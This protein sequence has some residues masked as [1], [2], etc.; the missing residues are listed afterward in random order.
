[1]VASPMMVMHFYMEQ[2]L[3]TK[4]S[5]SLERLVFFLQNIVLLIF[6]LIF[7]KS[8]ALKWVKIKIRKNIHNT[9]SCVCF[10]IISLTL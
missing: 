2:E 4:I 5:V 10:L 1:M 3:S 6:S 7:Q 9:C 8:L